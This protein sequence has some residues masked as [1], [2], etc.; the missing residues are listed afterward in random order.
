MNFINKI[1]SLLF[2]PIRVFVFH[3]VSEQFD[4]STM[5]ACDWTEI[6]QFKKKIIELQKEYKFISLD[7]ATDHLKTDYFRKTKYAVLTSDD[8]WESILSILPWLNE[9]NIPI[10]LFVNPAYLLKLQTRENGMNR[11]LSESQLRALLVQFPNITIASHGW[12]HDLCTNQSME[13]FNIS[14]K[15]SNGYLNS[16]DKY[17]NFFAFPCG[18]HTMEQDKVLANYGI[19]P[20]Y[21]DGMKNYTFE[22][23]I[24][25]ECIDGEYQ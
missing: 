25:R 20:V 16:F 9:R 5:W 15:Q 17:I 14:I 18:N 11:L 2:T 24:H 22:K 1:R 7:E 6:N 19:I 21:C 12:N 13:D 10:T 8:G 3:Q 4:E 23:G